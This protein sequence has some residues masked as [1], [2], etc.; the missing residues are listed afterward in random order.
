VAKHTELPIFNVSRWF[1]DKRLLDRTKLGGKFTR[2]QCTQCS[3]IFISRDYLFRHKALHDMSN[4]PTY[5]CDHCQRIFSHEILLKT[6]LFAHAERFP[7]A[8][9]ADGSKEGGPSTEVGMNLPARICSESEA[10]S[11]AGGNQIEAKSNADEEDNKPAAGLSAK[12]PSIEIASPGK[13]AATSI[14]QASEVVNTTLELVTTNS[15]KE[16]SEIICS[17]S[18]GNP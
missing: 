16:T 8:L 4:P 3:S 11:N 7:T 10:H 1:A 5:K 12:E 6:H 17:T 13:L 2:L 18:D 14:Y 9:V 15:I